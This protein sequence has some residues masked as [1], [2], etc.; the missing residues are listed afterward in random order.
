MARKFIT[1]N[2]HSANDVF[3]A[4]VAWDKIQKFYITEY[5]Q[6]SF[7][8]ASLS[9]A[10]F[11]AYIW[12]Y[13]N[14]EWT[15]Q[16]GN[17]L[18]LPPAELELFKNYLRNGGGHV[19][20]GMNP[21]QLWPGIEDIDRASFEELINSAC[22]RITDRFNPWTGQIE[23]S[24]EQRQNRCYGIDA[25]HE[26]IGNLGEEG[27]VS[28]VVNWE[29][30][31][32]WIAYRL[33][34]V[35]RGEY[36]GPCPFGPRVLEIPDNPLGLP[37]WL[38]SYQDDFAETPFYWFCGLQTFLPFKPPVE[39]EY[40]DEPYGAFSVGWQKMPIID[41]TSQKVW[42]YL[43]PAERF[44]FIMD[45]INGPSG[46][47]LVDVRVGAYLMSKNVK[48]P[49]FPDWYA[50]AQFCPNFRKYRIG[51]TGVPHQPN[52]LAEARLVPL[53]VDDDYAAY[54]KF[55]A[56]FREFL[57]DMVDYADNHPNV[58]FFNDRESKD[59]VVQQYDGT[60][61]L[62][63]DRIHAIS[64]YLSDQDNWQIDLDEWDDDNLVTRPPNNVRIVV[65]DQVEYYSLS[66]AWW[67]MLMAIKDIADG[68]QNIATRDLDPVLGPYDPPSVELSQ[69]NS[70]L[71]Q[72]WAQHN[73][74]CSIS[75]DYLKKMAQILAPN[76]WTNIEVGPAYTPSEI[77]TDR[78][79][80]LK[81]VIGIWSVTD[82]D[83]V[84]RECNAA[85]LLYLM[86]K[87]LYNWFNHITPNEISFIPSHVLP[88][89][90]YKMNL[91]H[92]YPLNC[93]SN[94]LDITQMWT[95]KPAVLQPDY[96]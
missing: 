41:D 7:R 3:N 80:Y 12:K 90:F 28:A 56:L 10:H 25:A 49:R 94:W 81:K 79:K 58:I 17:I 42:A 45:W 69:E 6:R 1:L 83:G 23:N 8:H 63:Q 86:A 21:G 77:G 96:R 15:A 27:R 68:Q 62:D 32:N 38:S 31:I 78:Q 19:F 74:S 61:S 60:V 59:M 50:T 43:T 57:D 65:N 24:D 76:C 95:M 33:C 73:N 66:E 51:N 14:T 13:G 4:D 82:T 87:G 46:S 40:S 67:Y 84:R 44:A 29:S 47:Q 54:G 55:K 34:G 89:Y 48:A 37:D 91:A 20:Y 70:Y 52:N 64:E 35:E 92:C 11:I 9:T 5:N 53:M 30:A 22:V 71:V 72:E 36:A 93:R 26:Y 85:E 18:A 88:K 16:G 2:H 39:D 75:F